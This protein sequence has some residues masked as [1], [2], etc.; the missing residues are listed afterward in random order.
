MTDEQRAVLRKIA[1]CDA[2]DAA[3]VL[4]A[5]VLDIDERVRAQE[6]C[7]KSFSRGP[8]QWCDNGPPGVGTYCT[9]CN[10]PGVEP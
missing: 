7:P 3:Q 1:S 4:A 10:L 6:H 2:S 5:A 9:Q 8:H